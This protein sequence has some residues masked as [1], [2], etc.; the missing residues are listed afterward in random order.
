MGWVSS[1]QRLTQGQVIAVDGKTLRRSH[2]KRAGPFD[3]L[4]RAIHTVSA[5]ATENSMVLGQTRT[6]AKSNKITAIPELL[7]LLDVS[8]C[9]VSIDAM[10]CQKEIARTIVNRGADY[11]LAVKENQG[12]LYDDLRDL[13]EGAEESG[14]DGVPHDFA[15]TLNKGHGRIERRKCWSVSDPVCLEYLSAAGD[16]PGLRTV[17]KV[18]CHSAVQVLHIQPGTGCPAVAAGDAKP[19]GIENSVHWSLSHRPVGELTNT[20]V[21]TMR[22]NRARPIQFH[23]PLSA[24]RKVVCLS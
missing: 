4:R 18:G 16:W 20:G 6:D 2:D 14:Y 8:G 3:K 1:V 22:L 12:R 19:L 23:R 24:P 10:G 21:G 11:V 7:K 13:F 17:E 5:C 15:T 9:I